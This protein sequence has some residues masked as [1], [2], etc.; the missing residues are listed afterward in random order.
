VT[1][2]EA[3]LSQ[4]FAAGSLGFHQRGLVEDAIRRL[5]KNRLALAALFVVLAFCVVAI[6]APV[7]ATHD[8]RDTN[9]GAGQ[10]YQGIS[11]EHWLGTDGVG[12]DWY[13][14]LV[15]GARTSLEVGIFSQLIVLA[16]GLPVGLV[17]G[18]AGGRLDSLLMRITDLAYAFPALLL[19]ILIS[20]VLG[21]S[22]F[23]IFF[24]IGI[25]SWTDHARLIRGQVLS[26]KESTYV[27]A[28]VSVG[29]SRWRVMLRHLLPN[30]LGPVI[31]ATTFGIPSAIFVEA[32]LSFIG[33]GLPPGS[34]SWGSMVN[35]GYAAI[36]GQ[37][38]LVIAPAAAIAVVTLAFTFL[39]DGL[40][41]A[42]DPRT[43]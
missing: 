21:P 39:G 27:L 10:Q 26:L 17:A 2:Q 30:T 14:R 38:V 41:D 6:L 15:F 28:A 32:T 13:S 12:R 5:A 37:E 33:V 20:Q 18:Y 25:V 43:R 4:D 9:F 36:F 34:A 40:R 42:L 23:N 16:I 35:D 7:F 24:A 31:V 29:A 3:A 11:A 8:Y 1:A 22:I 19:V